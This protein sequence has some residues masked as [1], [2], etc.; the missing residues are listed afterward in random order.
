M[1]GSWQIGKVK[2][3]KII[4]LE[5]TGGTRFIL[6]QAVPEVVKPI[7]WLFPHYVDER[8]RLKMSVH[9]LFIEADGL[10]IVVDTCLG[11][12]K[13]GRSVPDWNHRKSDFLER[14]AI[15]ACDPKEIDVVVCTHMHVDHVGWNTFWDGSAWQPSFP[16]ARYLFSKEEYEHWV[17]EREHDEQAAVFNDSIRPVI[18]C[19]LAQFVD[20]DH[21]ISA[22]VALEP[23][24]GH[25]PGHVSVRIT[26]EGSAA[27][28]T[29]DFIHHPCQFAFPDWA[30]SADADTSA[31]TQ[32]RYRMFNQLCCEQAL[33]IGTHFAGP[34]SGWLKASDEPG[35]SYCFISSITTKPKSSLGFNDSCLLISSRPL[36]QSTQ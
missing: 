16:N 15:E 14:F 17:D 21:A 2:I 1:Q 27:L 25:T 29:G 32:T 4:E 28:I 13:E 7:S 30:S 33:I 19:G 10:R 35:Q 34:S 24:P 26:S 8:G 6:P 11:N 9:A 22:S 20:M 12:D 36:D 5:R 31:S 18:E 3:R 23:T